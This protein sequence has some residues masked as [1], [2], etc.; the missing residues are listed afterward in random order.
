MPDRGEGGPTDPGYQGDQTDPL[1]SPTG[2][3]FD[4]TTADRSGY[5]QFIMGSGTK[6]LTA[7]EATATAYSQSTLTAAFEHGNPTQVK[8]A[9]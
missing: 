6:N 5:L 2:P 8:D 4:L 7:F 9:L 3:G 1:G